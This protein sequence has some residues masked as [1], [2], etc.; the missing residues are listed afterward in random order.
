MKV[1]KISPDH[2]INDKVAKL[3]E[4]DPGNLYVILGGEWE[5]STVYLQDSYSCFVLHDPTGDLGDTLLFKDGAESFL[6]KAH[7]KL[8]SEPITIMFENNDA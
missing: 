2:I 3:E 4:S 5:G 1:T 7:C 6:F 8:I